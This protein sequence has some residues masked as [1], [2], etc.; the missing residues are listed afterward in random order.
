[1]EIQHC[2]H[3]RC[4]QKLFES[5]GGKDQ[6]WQNSMLYCKDSYIGLSGLTCA[7]NVSSD[8][9]RYPLSVKW[10]FDLI[11]LD[12]VVLFSPQNLIIHKQSFVSLL[13]ETGVYLEA[14][15]VLLVNQYH[16]LPRSCDTIMSL[17]INDSLGRHNERIEITNE[18]NLA[19][20]YSW[21]VQRIP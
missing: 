1:M 8:H 15:K 5:Q 19:L 4:Q 18:F 3:F 21:I 13:R 10:K 16:R 7:S 12:D 17:E 2:L 20:L 9:E 14:E 6:S 11:C